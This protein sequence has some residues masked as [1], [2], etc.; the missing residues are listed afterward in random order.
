M[1]RT[2]S[3]ALPVIEFLT[4]KH[5]RTLDQAIEEA[6]IPASL[7]EHVRRYF[8]PTLEITPAAIDL[9]VDKAAS[10]PRCDPLPDAPEHYFGALRRYLI[11][12]RNRSKATVDAL[13]DTSL[14][15]LRRLPKPDASDGFQARGLVVGHIQS[16]KTASMAALIARAADQGY[17]LFIVLGGMTKDLR[18]QTQRRLDQEITGTSDEPEEAP[19]V[20]HD[21][22]VAR[23]VRLTRSGLP[24]DF[25][26]GGVNDLNP[27]TPKLAVIKKNVRIEHLMRWL[28]K[29]PVPL[30]EL[31]AIIFDDEADQA[32]IDTNYGKRDDEGEEIEPAT[33][34]RRIRD[35]LHI[36]PKHVYIGFTAT[37]FANVLIDANV[38][39]DLYPRDFIAALPEPPAYF[40]PRKLF[41]LG[42]GPSDLS[43]DPTHPPLLDVIRTIEDE[44][45]DEVNEVM[46]R[47]GE[48]PAIL[49]DA[50]LA[51]ILS[52]CGR[53]A[54]GHEHEHFSMLVHPS[55]RTAAHN[56]LAQ[57]IRDELV[58]LKGAAKHPASFPDVLRR[59]REMWETDFQG[60]TREQND[61][62]LVTSDFDTIWKFARSLI[63]SIEVK[64]LNS[65]PANQ[66][67]K[68]DYLKPAR[69]YVVVG[70]NRL[71]RGLTLEGL[72]VSVFTRPATNQY[73]T[74][75]QMGRWFGYRPQYQDLTRI[76]VDAEMREKFAD[77]A[78][79]EEELRAYL[80][81]YA[82]EPDPP[83]PLELKPMIRQHPT[84]A[85][86]SGMK[87]GAGRVRITFQNG[88]AQTVA[89]PV[90]NKAALRN[91]LEAARTF[92]A[93]LPG[94]PEIGSKGN[95]LVWKDV[96][97][98]AIFDLL[99]RYE[100]SRDARDVNRENLV[101]YIEEQNRRGELIAWDIV[102]PRGNPQQEPY[103]WTP[104]IVTHR[105]LRSPITQ[106]SI[107]IL[108]SPNDKRLWREQTGRDP[109]DPTRGAL[110]LYLIDRKSDEDTS[111]KFF[112]NPNDA[113][114]ILGLS[115]VFPASQSHAT[116]EYI[117]QP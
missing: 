70:G 77:L 111:V 75:L 65:D 52:S 28:E 112:P 38:P 47:G 101:S 103:A 85:V 40:G 3:D 39:D 35:L 87:M 4:T 34:N 55:P 91:N 76:Y 105:F 97:P 84:M 57:P 14:K 116:I 10:V 62:E 96:A 104:N 114:D 26:R 15:L 45:L 33:T 90:D 42:L 86:T 88:S 12:H 66:E 9:I 29:S 36:L 106:K 6:E 50:L 110:F 19:Y 54:R 73:D 46:T 8:A 81:Q 74:L 92:I 94:S 31:P 100:F 23:W 108:A 16:G 25:V 107:G 2:L 80:S 82:E 32:S 83:T 64:V 102:L 5:G 68:L 41:G 63:D 7:R 48:C 43:T 44:K 11:D 89:F 79:V 30:A 27:N 115:F 20:E 59:A 21:P 69:R 61:P 58:L 72:S 71:S 51:F 67:D 60:V 95:L 17:K 53:L 49:S 1:I 56:V 109:K 18:A 93:R 13:A 37:P 117:S 78:R 99:G 24:S 113:E 22:Q 98:D